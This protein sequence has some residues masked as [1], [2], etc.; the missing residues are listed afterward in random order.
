M[1]AGG[2]HA[3]AVG[4]SESALREARPAAVRRE[5]HGV[6]GMPPTE[7]RRQRPP[8]R[9]GNA[10]VVMSSY[11]AIIKPSCYAGGPLPMGT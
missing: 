8:T 7:A 2:H 9:R 1:R 5:P 10:A 4:L 6:A 11:R 3:G